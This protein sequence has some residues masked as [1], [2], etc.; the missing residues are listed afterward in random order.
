MSEEKWLFPQEGQLEPLESDE[1]WSLS[2]EGHLGTHVSHEKWAVYEA[3][4]FDC[5]SHFVYLETVK[6]VFA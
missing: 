4:L 3:V 2:Q 6:V 1:K 5:V